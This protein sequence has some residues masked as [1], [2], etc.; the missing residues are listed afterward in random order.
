MTR[1][2]LFTKGSLQ[3][4]LPLFNS[5]VLKRHF[6]T[7]GILAV[8]WLVA[9]GSSTDGV[10]LF[11]KGNYRE[12][13]QV[14]SEAVSK[15]P[16]DP[17][18]HFYLG[19]TYLAIEEAAAALPHLEKAVQL[20]PGNASYHFWL[21]VNHWALLDLDRELAA[22]E[23]ALTINPNFLPAHVYAGH[24]QLDRGHWEPA[25]GHYITVLQM[26]PE[27]PEGLY[28]AGMALKALGR[29][30]EASAVWRRYLQHHRSGRLGVEAARNLN[31]LGDF[32]YR[33]F[34]VDR[35]FLV[36]PSPGFQE[37]TLAID[38]QLVET[39]DEIGA[40]VQMNEALTLHIVTFV[41]G[42]LGLA[43]Q[44][45][46]AVK[47]AIAE[48]FPDISQNRIG[49]SW[50]GKAE[51]IQIDNNDYSLKASIKIFTAR[52]DGKEP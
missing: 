36:G 47:R 19:R 44:R 13:R 43:E 33:L 46:R 7:I 9:G 24:N 29:Q 22:Y 15:A 41:Q 10:A 18:G 3:G 42:D 32:S 37:E 35:R 14:L 52:T 12:A 6:V 34:A 45:A 17:Q 5:R 28:N 30:E 11:E 50:F 38:P 25:L 16:E 39:L 27:H 49:I 20:D 26:A 40:L 48:K 51:A 1:G 21:G 23:K 8:G 2:S 4:V 31:A